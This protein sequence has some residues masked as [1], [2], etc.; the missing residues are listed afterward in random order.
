M[1]DQTLQITVSG[2]FHICN[3]PIYDLLHICYHIFS[4]EFSYSFYLKK[5][6][7]KTQFV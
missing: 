3:H 4:V 6:F 7:E 5:V 2:V 1:V